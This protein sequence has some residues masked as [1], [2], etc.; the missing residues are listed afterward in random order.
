MQFIRKNYKLI[1]TF[2]I[3]LILAELAVSYYLIERFHETYLSRGEAL[4]IALDDAGL[5]EADVQESRI[6]F[7]HEGE[8]VWYE[9]TF[10]QIA[11]PGSVHAYQIDAGTGQILSA[12]TTP[13]H[14][15]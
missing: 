4:A 6:V 11:P 2:L 14:K 7:A 1:I 8:Q 10:E 5:Q 3:G 12:Q 15:K 9:V 13:Q